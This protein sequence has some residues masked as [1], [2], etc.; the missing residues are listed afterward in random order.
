VR[1]VISGDHYDRHPR[2]GNFAH[3]KAK[4]GFTDA[5]RV[6]KVADNKQ[7]VGTAAIGE[8]DHTTESAS[9][10][11]AK[12]IAFRPRAEGITLQVDV[13]GM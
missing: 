13:R 4:R 8:F 10:A 6:E 9:H 11:I 5:A 12:C 2:L 1:I 7:Q 3:R